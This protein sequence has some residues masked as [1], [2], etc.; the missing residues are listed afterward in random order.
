MIVTCILFTFP[1]SLTRCYFDSLLPVCFKKGLEGLI[2][3]L[4][5]LTLWYLWLGVVL[6]S[7][8]HTL[9]IITYLP[10]F[11]FS[12]QLFD[13]KQMAVKHQNPLLQKPN[14]SP[15]LDCFREMFRSFWRAATT[16]TFWVPSFIQWV[17]PYSLG[18]VG[19]G[20]HLVFDELWFTSFLSVFKN[21]VNLLAGLSSDFWGIF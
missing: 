11:C 6:E 15:S 16:R 21:H 13:G 2:W 5:N 17:C 8:A 9:R 7:L 10:Y 20:V 18:W 3:D 1:R 4:R 12:A 19:L 14:F